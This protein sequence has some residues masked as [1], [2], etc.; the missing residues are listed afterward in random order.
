MLSEHLILSHDYLL[1][2]LDPCQFSLEIL[3]VKP[4]RPLLG[5]EN[6]DVLPRALFIVFEARLVV[7]DL[8]KVTKVHRLLANLIL[9]VRANKEQALGH[10]EHEVAQVELAKLEEL[11]LAHVLVQIAFVPGEG[12]LRRLGDGVLCISDF[13]LTRVR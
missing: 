2:S 4:I 5:E 3:C 11:L 13:L 12:E 8:D 6:E 9:F 7:K 10:I 1:E